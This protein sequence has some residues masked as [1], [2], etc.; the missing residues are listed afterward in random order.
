MMEDEFVRSHIGKISEIVTGIKSHGGTKFNAELIWKIL[1]SLTPP[2]KKITK[3]IQLMIP[4]TQ[5]F[6][7][8]TLLGRLEVTELI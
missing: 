5:N 7:K 2:F 3:M 1:K 6:T 4:Y 8:E